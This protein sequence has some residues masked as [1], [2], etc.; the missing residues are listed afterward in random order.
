MG[1]WKI[2][3]KFSQTVD[4]T[5]T[6]FFERIAKTNVKVARSEVHQL[7][8]YFNGKVLLQDGSILHIRNMLGCTEEHIA[9]W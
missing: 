3:T 6:P 9:K 1:P 8:G 2:R 4:I 5:F 7:V